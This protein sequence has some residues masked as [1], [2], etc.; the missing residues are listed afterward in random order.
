MGI[1]SGG[2]GKQET[3]GSGSIINL[4]FNSNKY[5]TIFPAKSGV[6][7]RLSK[8]GSL[9]ATG[10]PVDTSA[11]V[12]CRMLWNVNQVNICDGQRLFVANVL[13]MLF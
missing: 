5:S 2:G 7:L 8:S 3:W 11:C 12:A 4:K 6:R 10:P 9:V 13:R 1:S